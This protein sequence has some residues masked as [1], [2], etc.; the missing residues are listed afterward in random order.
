[1]LTDKWKLFGK[2]PI[3]SASLCFRGL[4]E[5]EKSM[6]QICQPVGQLIGQLVSAEIMHFLSISVQAYTFSKLC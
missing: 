1:M 4:H 5:H 6:R 3:K 2:S